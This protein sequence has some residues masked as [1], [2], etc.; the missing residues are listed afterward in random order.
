MQLLKHWLPVSRN[1]LGYNIVIITSGIEIDCLYLEAY[2]GCGRIWALRGARGNT[3]GAK[4]TNTK[5]TQLCKLHHESWFPFISLQPVW[6]TDIGVQGSWSPLSVPFFCCPVGENTWQ[7][8]VG[9]LPCWLPLPFLPSVGRRRG[10]TDSVNESFSKWGEEKR[11]W[12]IMTA[13]RFWI[14]MRMVNDWLKLMVSKHCYEKYCLR[15]ILVLVTCEEIAVV[16]LKPSI[17]S[18]FWVLKCLRLH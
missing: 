14:L 3:I 9:V 12:F 2:T 17:F 13:L 10:G 6:S 18:C 11:G 1:Y 4:W 5:C 16:L 8:E 7:W 15:F